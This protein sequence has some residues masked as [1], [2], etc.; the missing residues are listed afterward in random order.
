MEDKMTIPELM[1]V[2]DV[3]GKI[4]TGNAT[5]LEIDE[6]FNYL[7]SEKTNTNQRSKILAINRYV[8]FNFSDMT[9]KII[10]EQSDQNTVSEDIAVPLTAKDKKVPKKRSYKPRKTKTTTRSKGRSKK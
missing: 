1:Y 4:Q 8:I 7:P 6:A 3:Y 2:M 9:T 10:N 5:D